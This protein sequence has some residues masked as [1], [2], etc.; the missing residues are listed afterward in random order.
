MKE[1]IIAAHSAKVYGKASVGSPPMSVPYLDTRTI[2]GEK[3]LLFGPYAGFSTKFLKNGSFLDLPLSIKTNN[4]LPM[5]SAGLGNIPLTKHLINQASQSPEDRLKALREY[6][7]D[8]Q[9]QDWVLE[10]AGQRVQVIKKDS[11][12][13]GIL[14]FGTK[15]V[16]SEDKT[17]A[18]LMGASPGASTSVSVMLKLLERCRLKVNSS[19]KTGE[20]ASN[21]SF[22]W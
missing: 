21:D 17:I 5:L 14:E 4:I 19:R 20:V 12:K 13:G 9:M 11:E 8:A 3:A 18:A 15:V 10:M 1:E 2:N 22:I 16:I 7:P 6:Y